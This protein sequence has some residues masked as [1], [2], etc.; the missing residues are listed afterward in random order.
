M[1]QVEKEAES[2]TEHAG[3]DWQAPKGCREVDLD[4]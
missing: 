3:G 2:G 1:H 4:S